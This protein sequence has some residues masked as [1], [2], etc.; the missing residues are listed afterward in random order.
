MNRELYNLPLV[1]L[2]LGSNSGDSRSIILEAVKALEEVLSH[3]QRASLYETDPL[4]V[5]DQARFI[6]TAVSGFFNGSPEALLATIH[7][8][9]ALFGRDR[10]RERRWGMRFLDIDILL[11]GDL[12]LTDPELFIPH[13]RLKERRFALEPLLELVPGAAEPGTG[14]SYKELCDAL[15]KQG[16][17][18][19]S[20][21]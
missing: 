9:E 12:V 21:I 19:I 18:K 8:I 4:Y 14:L 6:N 11:F 5:T 2:G 16:V 3:L 15:P 1:I 20:G 13:P 7:N 10:S 17:N